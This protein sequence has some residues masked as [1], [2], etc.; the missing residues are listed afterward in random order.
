MLLL[1]AIGLATNAFDFQ[2]NPTKGL[3]LSLKG[4]PVVRGSWFQYYAPGW[5]K[6][7]FNS[8][9][10][11]AKVV[12]VDANTVE[13]SWVSEDGLTI[14]KETLRRE[15]GK[16]HVHY[17]FDWGGESPA[18]IELAGATLWAPVLE[19]GAVLADGKE[20]RSLQPQKYGSQSWDARRYGDNSARYE[21]KVP[22]GNI[23]ISSSS[24]MTLLDGRDGFKQDWAES[25]DLLWLGVEDLSVEKGKTTTVDLDWQLQPSQLAAVPLQPVPKLTAKA[26]PLAYAIPEVHPALIP[27]PKQSN[28]DWDHPLEITGTWAFPAGRFR[29]F[30]EFQ[31]AL[32]RRFVLPTSGTPVNIDGGVSKLGLTPGAY[33][34]SIRPSGISVVGELDEGFRYGLQRIVRLAFAKDGKLYVPTGDLSDEPINTFRGVHLFVGPK[35]L[36][37]QKRLVE[38]VLMPLGM[39]KVVLQCERAAW[40]SLP[41]IATSETMSLEDLSKLFK[42]YRDY[43]FEPIPLIQSFGHD[44]W[45]FANG[46]NL[47]VAMDP[48]VPYA[49]DPRKTRTKELLTQLWSEAIGLL[50][51]E[52]VH[53]GLDEVDM[54]G[55][56]ADAHLK[57]QLWRTQLATLGEI[58][59][60]NDVKMMLWG[61]QLLG[62]QDAAD[63]TNGDTADEAEARRFA[64]PVHSIIA[65][66]HYL[67]DSNPA[68]FSPSLHLFARQ[69]LKPIA[70]TW[71]Q[72]DNIR[73]FDLAAISGGFGTLQTTWAGYTSS[74]PAMIENS[75]QFTAMVLA[76]DF[77]WSGRQDALKDLD[78]DYSE[79][80]KQMYFARPASV[81]IIGG[82]TF[83]VGDAETV[84]IGSVDFR[85]G[86]PLQL[87]SNALASASASPDQLDIPVTVSA[88]RLAFALTAIFPSNE[89]AVVGELEV[90]LASGKKLIQPL[91]YGQHL[92]A[93]KDGLSCL[94]AE[95]HDGVSC[96]EF[97]FG[98]A[99][100]QVKSVR[101]SQLNQYSGLHLLGITAY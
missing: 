100:A 31:D 75:K 82:K 81:G 15:E 47:D 7:Y 99:P 2:V 101:I 60:K 63:A 51:P 46:Q 85:L 39:N 52:T 35:S 21:F 84:R 50:H 93:R 4:V 97:D 45:L 57:T 55:F 19:A 59:K 18:K 69:G 11:W 22:F 72:P 86:E 88:K 48:K 54:A 68:R 26:D 24:P 91:V 70:S 6:G 27:K 71:Y 53:F 33:R 58:A 78:Y 42:M 76:A 17:A 90:T 62:P 8:A 38:R 3:S 92:R 12:N 14:A 29:F 96:V 87:R 1:A 74:E 10:H 40:K 41:G 64:V 65:D 56:P 44:E 77:G 30:S 28:L 25:G 32:A 73:G 89:G 66:W 37:F 95:R 34:I 49:L 16:L 23:Q 36:E 13:A 94:L 80:F 43:G 5:S 79:V 83:S 9:N 67:A 20:T 98:A 61:D